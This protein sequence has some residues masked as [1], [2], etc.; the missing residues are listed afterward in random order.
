MALRTDA[1]T[2]LFSHANRKISNHIVATMPDSQRALFSS[3]N[4]GFPIQLLYHALLTPSI[5][6]IFQSQS[7]SLIILVKSHFQPYSNYSADHSVNIT[8]YSEPSC[9]NHDSYPE[10]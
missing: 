9:R 5:N 2:Y 1:I 3:K 4:K 8:Y 6:K 7:K 10:T